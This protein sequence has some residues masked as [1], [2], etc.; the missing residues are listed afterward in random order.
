MSDLLPINATPAERAIS[1][2]IERHAQ[3][4]IRVR[5]MWN[6]DSCPENLLAWMAWA[7]GVDEWDVNWTDIQKRSVIKRSV[8]VHR[9]KGTIGAVRDAGKPSTSPTGNR[10]RVAIPQR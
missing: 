7:F 5:E 10:G 6:P 8:V 2:A 1:L 4:P 9:Y 3:V